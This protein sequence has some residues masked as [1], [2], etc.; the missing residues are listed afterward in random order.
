MPTMNGEP[1]LSGARVRFETPFDQYR[2]RDGQEATYLGDVDPT[3][4][5]FEETGPLHVIR[6]DDGEE[7]QAWPEEIDEE[8]KLSWRS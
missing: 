2:S 4:F 7:I 8:E 6:F 5:D 3:T 1:L